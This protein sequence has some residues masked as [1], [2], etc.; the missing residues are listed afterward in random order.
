MGLIKLRIID[1]TSLLKVL[2]TVIL[3]ESKNENGQERQG[4][5]Y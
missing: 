1:F 5:H 4:Q 3:S 2:P